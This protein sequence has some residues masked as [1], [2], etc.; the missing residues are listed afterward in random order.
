MGRLSKV[1]FGVVLG[2]AS[3]NFVSPI[4]EMC[5]DVKAPCAEGEERPGC[6][7]LEASKIKKEA[8]VMLWT[9]HDEANQDFIVKEGA[10]INEATGLC[11]DIYSPCADAEEEKAG[12][13]DCKRK[14][15]TELGAMANV[16]MYTCHGKG[17]QLWILANNGTIVNEHAGLCL[18]IYAPCVNEADEKAGKKDCE[19]TKSVDM[20]KGANVQ[21]YTCHTQVYGNQIW[22]L[23]TTK[24]A[25][26]EFSAKFMFPARLR[27]NPRSGTGHL[28]LGI[29][30]VSSLA[31]AMF[32]GATRIW[33]GKAAHG[34]QMQVV[35]E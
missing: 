16:Q 18:D 5:M 26:K 6:K 13:K 21:V 11:L 34:G 20:K 4:T 12:K 31:V 28:V 3:A 29:A 9:C 32:V 27:R 23:E 19:R 33:R 2:Y 15:A 7:R 10:V 25:V 8:N 1:C 22:N 30:G 14:S 17:N 24:D 35:A